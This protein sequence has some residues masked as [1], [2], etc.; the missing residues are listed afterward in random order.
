MYKY[1]SCHFL[2]AVSI[3]YLYWIRYYKKNSLILTVIRQNSSVV[4]MD[5]HKG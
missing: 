5:F 1:F 4:H 3:Q 2:N